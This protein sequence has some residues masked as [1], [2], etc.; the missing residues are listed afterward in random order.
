MRKYSLVWYLDNVRQG[1]DAQQRWQDYTQ[2]KIAIERQIA[3]WNAVATPT[4]G[5]LA[6]KESRLVALRKE[7]ADLEL[8]WRKPKKD[9]KPDTSHWKMLVQAEAA[10]RWAALRK[11]GANPTKFS[12]RDDLAIWCRATGIKTKT[13]INPSAETI[14]RH[15]L[16]HW[17]PPE[18]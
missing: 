16:G 13:G 18:D 4:A 2:P 9:V 11:S 6:Q 1:Q 3:K 7:L 12:I 17:T 8:K 14:Y 15:A 5:E 10:K